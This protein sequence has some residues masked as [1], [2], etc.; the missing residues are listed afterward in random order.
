L[1]PLEDLNECSCSGTDCVGRFANGAAIIDQLVE[2]FDG[3]NHLTPNERGWMI[4][5]ER[6]RAVINAVFER[7]GNLIGQAIIGPVVALDPELL[8]V[9]AFP[10]NESLVE[11]IRT[12]LKKSHAYLNE[13]NGV[14]AGT[15][16]T[17]DFDTTAMGAARL[18]IERSLVPAIDEALPSGNKPLPPWRLSAFLRQHLPDG[19]DDS[20]SFNPPYSRLSV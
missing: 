16:S 13:D 2:Y 9:S 1:I 6:S 10:R 15:P 20:S 12:Q 14:V 11:G 4:E 3:S 5:E 17:P 18:A 19:V 8:V 7:A